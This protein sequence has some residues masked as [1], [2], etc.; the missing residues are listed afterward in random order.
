[1]LTQEGLK[2][3]DLVHLPEWTFDRKRIFANS[4]PNFN[5]HANCNR[6]LKAQK[7]F[8]ENKMTSFFGQV[9]RYRK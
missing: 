7:P 3:R 4:N 9:F 1:V 6:N 8:R 2:V 5:S